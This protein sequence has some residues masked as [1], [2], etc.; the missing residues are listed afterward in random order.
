VDNNALTAITQPLIVVDNYPYDGNINS[1]NPND[2]GE[3]TI[4]KDA[5][6]CIFLGSKS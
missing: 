3:I 2:M 1:I 4:L 6:N 5:C